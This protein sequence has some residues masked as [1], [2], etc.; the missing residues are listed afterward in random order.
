MA[1]DIEGF[2]KKNKKLIIICCIGFIIIAGGIIGYKYYT[3]YRDGRAYALL[4]KGVRLYIAVGDSKTGNLK[5][6]K[7]SIIMLHQLK[8]KYKGTKAEIIANFYL[9]SDYLLL[10]KYKK[11]IIYFKKYTLRE[12]IPHKNNISY[13]AYSNIVTAELYQKNDLKAVSYLK[14][15]TKIND[16]KLKEY[17]MLEEASIY[18]MI[19]KPKEAIAVY[20]K[21]LENDAMTKNRGHIENLIQLNS[22]R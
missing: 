17:A 18:T 8:T 19:G 21:M 6:V 15:M 4:G 22:K 13:L 7:K 14:K 9:G 10:R 16:V 5:N 2:F 12:P 20:K 1:I 11:A 3:G